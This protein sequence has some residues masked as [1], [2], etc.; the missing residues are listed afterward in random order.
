[1]SELDKESR[2]KKQAN[3]KASNSTENVVE[4]KGHRMVLRFFL[5]QSQKPGRKQDERSLNAV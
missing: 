2:R 4:D 1:M 3:R 5:P